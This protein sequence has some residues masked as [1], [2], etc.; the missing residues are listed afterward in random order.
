MRFVVNANILFSIMKDG[1]VTR[2]LLE[3]SEVSLYSPK[4]ALKELYKYQEEIKRKNKID[5]FG[6]S[7]EFLKKRIRFVD[8]EEYFAEIKENF[9]K[10]K[11]QKDIDYIALASKLNIPLWTNDK[12]LKEQDIVQ[13]LNTEEIIDLLED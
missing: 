6:E 9:F 3:K 4:F 12:A 8:T 2:Q 11:D 5:N 13:V 10:I 7:V 1:S